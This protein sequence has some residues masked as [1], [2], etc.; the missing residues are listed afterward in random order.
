MKSRVL[1]AYKNRRPWRFAGI[2]MDFKR[3]TREEPEFWEGFNPVGK[4]AAQP[5]K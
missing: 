4:K 1:A 2:V 3:R 5:L